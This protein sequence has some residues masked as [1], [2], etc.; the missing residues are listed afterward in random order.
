MPRVADHPIIRAGTCGFGPRP[1]E[2]YRDFPA[3]EVQQTL[4]HSSYLMAR[5]RGP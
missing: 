1:Q 4:Y 2:D 3:V 5:A